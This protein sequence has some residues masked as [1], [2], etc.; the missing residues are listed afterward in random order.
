MGPHFPTNS[1]KSVRK[2]WESYCP[3]GSIHN[4]LDK[5][6]YMHDKMLSW[7]ISCMQTGLVAKGNNC[8]DCLFA[9]LE[10]KALPKVGLLLKEGICS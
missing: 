4:F 1:S 9:L 8:C 2:Y 10:D 6:F 5:L 7:D 3:S